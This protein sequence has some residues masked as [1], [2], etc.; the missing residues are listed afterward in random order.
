MLN[1]SDAAPVLAEGR[2]GGESLTETRGGLTGAPLPGH[3]AVSARA[4][5]PFTAGELVA[6]YMLGQSFVRGAIMQSRSRDRRRRALW[7]EMESRGVLGVVKGLR[8]P[9][10]SFDCMLYM[11]EHGLI[12]D[13]L[14]WFVLYLLDRGR[15][16]FMLFWRSADTLNLSAALRGLVSLGDPRSDQFLKD[17]RHWMMW[18]TYNPWTYGGVAHGAGMRNLCCCNPRG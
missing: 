16:A 2:A 18:F 11:R 14:L 5:L 3:H 17:A 8:Y 12:S 1:M 15:D 7:F 10:P 6:G 9:V 4:A 13:A